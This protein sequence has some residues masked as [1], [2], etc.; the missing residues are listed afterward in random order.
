M[1]ICNKWDCYLLD[2]LMFKIT[3]TCLIWNIV[4]KKITILQQIWGCSKDLTKIYFLR[5]K[6][7]ITKQQALMAFLY[8]Y[9]KTVLLW[10]WKYDLY[11]LLLHNN[12]ILDPVS[13]HLFVIWGKMGPPKARLCCMYSDSA[14]L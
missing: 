7:I 9:Q 3:L 6:N 13:L 8:N 14:F 2:T 10:K 1:Y 4:N 5:S 11:A 12:Y